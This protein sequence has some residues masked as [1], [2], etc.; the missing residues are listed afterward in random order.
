MVNAVAGIM[1]IGLAI[2]VGLV[3]A[4]IMAFIIGYVLIATE[5]TLHMN[6]AIPAMFMAGVI[7]GLLAIG[8]G[9]EIQL[10]DAHKMIVDNNQH[11]FSEILLH[12]TGK[13]SEILFFLIGAM[14]IVELINLHNGFSIVKDWIKTKDKTKLLWIIGGL[15]FILSALIDNLTATIVLVT[16]IR[17]LFTHQ[18]TRWW[19]AGMVII[20]ANAGGAWSPIGDVT[21]TMLWIANK[22][23]VV[24][25]IKQVVVPAVLCFFVPFYLASRMNAFKGLI[26]KEVHV[27][28]E[29]ATLLSSRIMLYGGL[30]M[31]VFV[32]IFKTITHLPPYIGMII[33][34]AVVWLMSE[35][36]Q[37]EHGEFDKKKYNAHHALSRIEM[38]S[39]LFFLGI[40]LA[41]GGLESMVIGNIGALEYAAESINQLIPDQRIVG[42]I[43]G[44]LSALIDN[45][46]L[47]A[48]A[49]GMFD[50]PLDDQMWHL[51]AY[52]AGTGGSMIIIGSAAGVAAMG[53]EKIP[54]GWYL[55]NI[56]L[57]ALVGFLAGAVWFF[58]I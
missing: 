30:A 52:A 26:S 25:L 3:P 23:T 22:V 4:I 41:V 42:V 2:I 45:V 14:T 15:A 43:L 37:P 1:T 19:Y 38:S 33:A 18:Q 16:I 8:F 46:P 56:A 10:I 32:P 54:F 7:W 34:V 48:A 11:V 35:Y 55:K 49:L 24:G 53:M 29:E 51:I 31:I 39:I 21:T 17:K 20:A 50:F 40:L 47:V 12:H 58:I 13:I 44:G 6:K 28:E 27:D 36:I 5:H 57:L 9:S